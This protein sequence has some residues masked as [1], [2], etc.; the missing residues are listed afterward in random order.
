MDCAILTTHFPQSIPCLSPLFFPGNLLSII[1]NDIYL[2]MCVSPL[3]KGHILSLPAFT[4]SSSVTWQEEESSE[5]LL[6]WT[7]TF[8]NGGR[9]QSQLTWVHSSSPCLLG[10]AS[11][12]WRPAVPYDRASLLSGLLVAVTWKLSIQTSVG[13]W[14]SFSSHTLGS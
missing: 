11:R 5:F 8:Y 4:V 13:A 7:K 10:T 14:A 2:F 12:Y 9:E 6:N 3:G 1:M